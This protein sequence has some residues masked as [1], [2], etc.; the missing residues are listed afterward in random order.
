MRVFQLTNDPSLS[1]AISWEPLETPAP[2]DQWTYKYND[3]N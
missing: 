1:T 3:H 2:K